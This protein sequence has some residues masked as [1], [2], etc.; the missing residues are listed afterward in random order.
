MRVFFLVALCVGAACGEVAN[1]AFDPAV[2]AEG[3]G[4]G[5]VL[6]AA[7]ADGQDAADGDDGS[8]A[9][10]GDQD[11]DQDAAAT[12][13]RD[14]TWPKAVV[15]AAL[16]VFSPS[17][18]LDA[19]PPT[20]TGD[21][22]LPDSGSGPIKLDAGASGYG[23]SDAGRPLVAHSLIRAE[24]EPV[25]DGQLDDWGEPGLRG[26]TRL[27]RQIL[28]AVQ[29]PQDLAATW[30]GRWT[31]T[32]LFV[33]VHVEDDVSVQDGPYPWEDDAVEIFLDA[34]GSFALEY[35]RVD[36]VQLVFRPGEL[37]MHLGFGTQVQPAGVTF[38]FK[39]DPG[40]AGYTFEAK[41]PFGPHAP[42]D[43][44]GFDVHVDDDDL[45]D[46]RDAKITWWTQVDDSWR[47][48]D[49]FAPVQL[50]P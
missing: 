18:L 24:A 10:D 23:G 6:D 15:D 3:P 40:S 50:G 49:L 32:Y 27:A 31:P 17:P 12:N 45:G 34:N 39:R 19:G 36:D 7:V 9:Q 16:D 29:S 42:G 20:R 44:I 22:A 5:P 2:P 4:G 30:M 11:G 43:V 37:T 41:I 8:G 35:D 33:A 26:E 46:R 47:R 21:A 28:G 38:A 25:I 14:A 1:P 48:P 13:P